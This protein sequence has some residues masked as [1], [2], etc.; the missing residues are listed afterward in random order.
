MTAKGK[1]GPRWQGRRVIND[2][3]STNVASAVLAL[4]NQ[5]EPV[6]LLAGGQGKGE[7]YSPLGELKDHVA[8]ALTFGEQGPA[9]AKEFKENAHVL[10]SLT[11]AI[12][13]LKSNHQDLPPGP[14]LLSPACA[15]FDEFTNFEERGDVFR[16]SLTPA[17]QG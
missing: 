14:V 7:D 17:V 3:K 11:D 2:S 6:I 10:P 9:I 5:S 8:M 13:W 4:K 1:P 16:R 12:V 15:S